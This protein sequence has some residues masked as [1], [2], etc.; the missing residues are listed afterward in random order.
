MLLRHRA[1]TID[2]ESIRAA[3]GF[4]HVPA[5]SI[6]VIRWLTA[7]GVDFVLVGAVARAIRG[8]SNARGPVDVVPAP[9]GR[10]LDRLAFALTAVRARRRSPGELVGAAPAASTAALKLTAE[11]L[12]GTERWELR[13]GDHDLDIEGRPPG[14]PSY[15][16]LLYEAVRFRVSPEV[17][18]EVAAPEDIEQYDHVRRT[19]L[20]PEITVTR[21]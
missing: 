19:G 15:Q 12:V 9:Y 4:E 3:E 7:S 17:S 18:V 6:A 14:S 20:A 11:M 1:P 21:L 2:N 8:E 10:N 5:A 16:E 13:C